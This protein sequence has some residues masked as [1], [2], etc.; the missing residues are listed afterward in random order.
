MIE[1]EYEC[2]SFAIILYC[3]DEK[4]K[5]GDFNPNV[6]PYQ[7]DKFGAFLVNLQSS[8]RGMNQI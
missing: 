4:K 6:F 3:G 1:P 5:C 7:Y 2:F 8:T